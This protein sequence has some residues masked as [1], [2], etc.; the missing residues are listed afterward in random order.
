V[1]CRTALPQSMLLSSRMPVVRLSGA[2]SNTNRL[3]RQYLPK[4]VRLDG[5]DQ[6]D[7]DVF[8]LRLNKRPRKVLGFR[9]PAHDFAEVM[10]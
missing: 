10:P 2:R 7:L 3:I 5:Y 4:G 9:C 8:A 1:G 6:R